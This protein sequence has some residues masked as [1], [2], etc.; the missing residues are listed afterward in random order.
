MPRQTSYGSHWWVLRGGSG[1]GRGREGHLSHSATSAWGRLAAPGSGPPTAWLSQADWALKIAK[2]TAKP[3]GLHRAHGSTKVDW[4]ERGR[5]AFDGGPALRCRTPSGPR[6]RRGASL[7]ACGC[8]DDLAAASRV[9]KLCAC[10]S[11]L[12]HH[13]ATHH[14]YFGVVPHQ[15]CDDA[16]CDRTGRQ[17]HKAERCFASC[18]LDPAHGIR[19]DKAAEIAN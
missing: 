16:C 6:G 19:A 8:K 10:F 15:E 3:L 18:I 14:L 1:Q 12:R 9:V 7:V 11:S 13:A 2:G 5:H 17:R 4:V